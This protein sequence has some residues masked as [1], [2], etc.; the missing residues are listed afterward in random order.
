M[1]CRWH[2]VYKIIHCSAYTVWYY[3]EGVKLL[4]SKV[5]IFRVQSGKNYTGQKNFTQTPSVVSVTNIRY[6]SKLIKCLTIFVQCTMLETLNIAFTDSRP[7]QELTSV[8]DEAFRIADVHV[9]AEQQAKAGKQG[10]LV[11]ADNKGE[12]PNTKHT[13]SI[14][15]CTISKY[16]T[17]NTPYQ[18]QIQP[19]QIHFTWQSHLEMAHSSA[20]E[21]A[22]SHQAPQW[23][24]AWSKNL[25]FLAVCSQCS[26]G[27]K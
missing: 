6:V 7:V 27:P 22:T 15:K 5:A 1:L 4:Y 24:F 2:T 23:Y 26:S 16:Q 25:H 21:P 9:S 19:Y 8:R 20:E 18:I 11:H 17:P 3:T 13:I 12:T 10:S 14:T